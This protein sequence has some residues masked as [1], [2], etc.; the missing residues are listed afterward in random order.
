VD[1]VWPEHG[2]IVE[3]DGR[4]T[5]DNPFA[6]HQDRE[7]DLDLELADLRVLRLSWWQVVHDE[8]RVVTLLRRRLAVRS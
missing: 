4:A 1:F 3:T 8:G 2:L 5:H 6:F 7:R